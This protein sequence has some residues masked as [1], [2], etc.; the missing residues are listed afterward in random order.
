MSQR[1]YVYFQAIMIQQTSEKLL[2]DLAGYDEL[3][4]AITELM[5]DLKHQHSELFDSW[6][7]ELST[8]IN[9]KKLRYDF[10]YFQV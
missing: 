9:N 2:N 7:R 6:T 1:N 8:Q 4:F 3:H 5:K 10:S